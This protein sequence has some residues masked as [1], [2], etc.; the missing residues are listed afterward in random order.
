M[1][2]LEQITCAGYHFKVQLQCEFDDAGIEKIELRAHVAVCQS[3]L[4]KRDELYGGRT[5]AI[6][7]LY[8]AREG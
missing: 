4:C 1:S 2:R 5:E 7:L 3:P 8:K 6:I